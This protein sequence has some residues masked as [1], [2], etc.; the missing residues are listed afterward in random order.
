M[1]TIFTKDYCPYCSAAKELI[2]NLGFEYQEID[3]TNDTDKFIEIR[4]LS[5]MMTVPQIF[6][7]PLSKENSLGGYSDIKKLHDEW[8]LVERL[9]KAS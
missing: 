2:K 7:W 8:Q 5:G 4:N 1:I 3:V 6:A 9:K